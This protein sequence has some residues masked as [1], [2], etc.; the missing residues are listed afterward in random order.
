MWPVTASLWL[1]PLSMLYAGGGVGWYHTTFDYN[2]ALPLQDTTKQKFGVHLGGGL[3]L[4]LAPVLG[5]DLQGRYVF[6]NKAGIPP[7]PQSFNP[8]YWTTSLGLA[9]KF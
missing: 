9:I 8:D 2:E 5:L 1:T 7:R 6:L 4:P 3:T